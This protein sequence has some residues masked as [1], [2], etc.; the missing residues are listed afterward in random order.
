[1]SINLTH[2]GFICF[3]CGVTGGGLVAFHMKFRGLGFIETCKE[4]GAWEKTK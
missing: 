4:L 3:A 1:M 2:G